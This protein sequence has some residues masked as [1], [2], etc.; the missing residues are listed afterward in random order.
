MYTIFKLKISLLLFIIVLNS[1]LFAKENNSSD[2][3]LGTW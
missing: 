2:F 3:I 1:N